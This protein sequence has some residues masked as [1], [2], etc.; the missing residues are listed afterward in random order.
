M[1]LFIC[2][3]CRANFTDLNIFLTHR[4]TCNYQ[5]TADLFPL[6]NSPSSTL[7]ERELDAIIEDVSLT[8]ST[9]PEFFY[10]NI[11][12][13]VPTTNEF[14]LLLPES[15]EQ[16][17][18]DNEMIES[19]MIEDKM[20]QMSLLECPV[21]DEQFDAP[22]VLEDHVFEHST[23]V[24]DDEN[25]NSKTGLP[26]DD[27]SSSYIDMIDEP[28]TTYLE[29]KQCTVRFNSNASLSIHKK[30]SKISSVSL[31][32][33]G[34]FLFFLVHCLNP[35]FR[36][37]NEACAQLFEKPVDYILHA[38]VHS[39]KRHIGVRRPS[40]TG[41]YHRYR[42][43][44]Y[45]CRLC[46][47]SFQTSD[48][49][50]DHMRNDIHKF[51][52]QLCPAEFD[53][54]NSYHNHIAKHPDLALYRCTICIESFQKRNDLSRHVMTQHNQA[55]PKQK[56]CSTCKLTFKTT[57]H[58]NRHNVTKHSDTKPFKCEQDG[59]EQAFAR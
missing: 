58:L 37:L 40:R 12:P 24:E 28:S 38:R 22:K 39:Q 50:D 1:D 56:S 45:R 29:C 42:K 16:N 6:T 34:L 26:F 49:L 18:V 48:Q 17:P 31:I 20:S 36:C 2:G 57:F 7:L 27:S 13:D 47:K 44:T 21:C 3:K 5:Q 43:R 23:W 10:E 53:S 54:N 25:L 19:S 32:K 51:I 14:D 4:S 8:M 11:N 46:K 55:L 30:M 9:A 15:V 35:V 59:C 52:C 41:A 33:T